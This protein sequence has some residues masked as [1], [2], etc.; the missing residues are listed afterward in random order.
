MKDSLTATLPLLDKE[1][2][3]SCW[4]IGDVKGQ[5]LAWAVWHHVGQHISIRGGDGVEYG[6][7]LI[8][9]VEDKIPDNQKVTKMW[10]TLVHH[11]EYIDVEEEIV[12]GLGKFESENDAK[13]VLK[14]AK[15]KDGLTLRIRTEKTNDKS[16]KATPMDRTSSSLRIHQ[17][18][19]H[20]NQHQNSVGIGFCLQKPNRRYQNFKNEGLREVV[21]MDR[22][23]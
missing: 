14:D 7:K 23:A 9:I 13:K 12:E 11:V 17:P 22:H 8:A 16:G 4:A 18:P 10:K 20:S 1:R 15:E 3:L 21:N 2:G 6:Y 19:N 5:N